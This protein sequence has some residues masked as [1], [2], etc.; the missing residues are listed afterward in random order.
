MKNEKRA[1]M[2]IPIPNQPPWMSLFRPTR[3]GWRGK[4]NVKEIPR[5]CVRE[6]PWIR[7]VPYVLISRDGKSSWK[8][9]YL[10]IKFDGI[11]WPPLLRTTNVDTWTLY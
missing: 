3:S 1:T 8:G 6:T 11:R 7:I 10:V 5:E 9:K 2:R 4:I